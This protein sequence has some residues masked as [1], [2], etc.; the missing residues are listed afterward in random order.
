MAKA[1]QKIRSDSIKKAKRP[2][3]N[4]NKKK[5]LK[6][7]QLLGAGG[8]HLLIPAAQRAEVRRTVVQSRPGK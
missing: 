7:T 2:K 6:S 3:N 8:S 4:N 5:Q 1:F